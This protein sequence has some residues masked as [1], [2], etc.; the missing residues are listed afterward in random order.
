[1]LVF[2]LT[3]MLYNKNKSMI[4]ELAEKFWQLKQMKE[5][6]LLELEYKSEYYIHYTCILQI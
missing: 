1:M 5:V 2:E 3:H 4:T 6:N